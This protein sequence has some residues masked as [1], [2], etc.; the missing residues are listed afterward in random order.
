MSYLKIWGRTQFLSHSVMVTLPS[1]N[2]R[3][4]QCIKNLRPCSSV[5]GPAVRRSDG[6][7][8]AVEL[9]RRDAGR[10]AA[11]PRRLGVVPARLLRARTLA[12]VRRLRPLRQRQLRGRRGKRRFLFLFLN[13]HLL[14]FQSPIIDHRLFRRSFLFFFPFFCHSLRRNFRYW[15]VVTGCFF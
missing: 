1:K 14:H 2:K 8:R 10:A 5:T 12:S 15:I 3:V 13:H 6:H 11:R 9:Q 4:R 7:A